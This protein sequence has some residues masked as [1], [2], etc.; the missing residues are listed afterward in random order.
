MRANLTFSVLSGLAL[1]VTA[2][3]A[4]SVEPTLTSGGF[5]GLGVT[6]NARL[7]GWG[8]AGIAYDNSLPGNLPDNTGHNYVVGFGIFPNL[9]ASLRLAANTLHGS[10]FTTACGNRD[11][12]AS[13]KLAIGIDAA[14]RYSIAVGATD[15]G[16]GATRYRAYYGVAS[17][18]EGDVEASIGLAQRGSPHSSGSKSPLDGVF[19]SGAWQPLPWIRGHLE[20]TDS[21]AWAGVRL[22]APQKW[23]P[24]GWAAHVGANFR[25]TDTNLTERSWVTVGV[26]IPLYKT[27]VL[28]GQAP[29]GPLPPLAGS[30]ER[31]PAFEARPPAPAAPPTTAATSQVRP[32]Q[33]AAAPVEDRHVHELVSALHAKGFEDISVGRMPDRSVAVRANN[34]TY[35]W[36]AA[37]A[38]G[39]ALGAVA[40]TLAPT[41]AGYR[42]VLTQRQI[43]LVAVTGQADC[44]L[45]WIQNANASCTAGE[46]S[47]PGT[48]PLEALHEDVAW[49]VRNAH[50]SRDTLRVSLAPV[51]RT[52]FGTELG[53]YDYSVGV[54]VGFALPVWDG[55][56]IE[57]RHNVAMAESSDFEAGSIFG[58]RR[59]RS[60][61]ERLAVVQTLRLPLER[62]FPPRNPADISRLG[63]GSVTAQASVGRFGMDYDG[64]HGML[65]W[66]PGQGLHRLTA[67]A[68]WFHN[69]DFGNVRDQ[70]GPKTA[71]P[72]LG[73]YRYALMATRTYL[74]A[75]AGQ[76][77]NN[78][79]GFQ[80]GIRQWF[81]D[82]AVSAYYKRTQFSGS[83]A[84][85]LLGVE[86]SLPL[87]PRR[88]M[89]PGRWVQVTGTP[90]FG[91]S[92]ETSIR[93]GNGNPQ[94]L[95]H[96]TLAPTPSLDAT[97]NSD[98]SS[99]TYFEDNTRRIRDAA[100]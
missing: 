83:P 87:G 73:S 45:E 91:H 3:M 68:G 5:T 97:F 43:P 7:I 14:N 90:R 33:P 84:R 66:E 74:E 55:A 21:N 44:L 40:R 71:K 78:D 56:T 53:A 48:G 59:V 82:V 100:R 37:D 41:R 69:N 8:H 26:S 2:P 95:G 85:D 70:F 11:L 13:G 63:L 6:P 10:C 31:L 4:H 27:P 28:P 57:Y 16:G 99:L 29:K 77:M 94:R 72:F 46:L 23:L 35:N 86:I 22:F 61:V 9:E 47:T 15:V 17:Y 49:T 19:A 89:L 39:V 96:G 88:D 64:L 20:Y 76:F 81:S 79:R 60:G 92:I 52:T 51:L 98:R 58:N 24:E 62:W 1:A 80:L 25:L 18:H 54:N 93:E 38:L 50:A 75:T 42:L 67:Q 36:N 65:R 30:Q 34:A 32:P 12:S